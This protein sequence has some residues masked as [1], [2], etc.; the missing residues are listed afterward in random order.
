MTKPW[1]HFADTQIF[2]FC[3]Q[4]TFEIPCISLLTKLLLGQTESDAQ[5][6]ENG[7]CQC[8]GKDVTFSSPMSDGLSK[9]AS[10]SKANQGLSHLT[11]CFQVWRCRWDNWGVNKIC[12]H[13]LHGCDCCVCFVDPKSH[14]HPQ[15][16][17][18]N[19]LTR[20]PPSI[21]SSICKCMF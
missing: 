3:V 10:N 13:P 19:S 11:D 7:N 16:C 4:L 2:H 6:H 18:M 1:S 8:L 15:I 12:P 14:L 17:R 9:R 5:F 20:W 21:I